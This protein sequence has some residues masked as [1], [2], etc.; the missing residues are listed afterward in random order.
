MKTAFLVL[1]LPVVLS[2]ATCNSKAQTGTSSKNGSEFDVFNLETS[3]SRPP[4]MVREI[5][6]ASQHWYIGI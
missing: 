2:L 6:L 1:G 3:N 4:P 5:S